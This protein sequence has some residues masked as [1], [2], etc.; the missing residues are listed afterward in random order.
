MQ[1][2]RRQEFLSVLLTVYLQGLHRAPACGKHSRIICQMNDFKSL[3]HLEFILGG[4]CH[5]GLL[6]VFC[7]CILN[8]SY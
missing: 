4:I 1:A 2:P 3:L 8:I 5:L 6:Y 7:I